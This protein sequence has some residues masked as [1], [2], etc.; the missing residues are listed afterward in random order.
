MHLQN[1][2]HWL[3]RLWRD[4][5]GFLNSSELIVLAAILILGIIPGI[6][7]LRRAIMQEFAQQA[8]S[9][10]GRPVEIQSIEAQPERIHVASDLMQ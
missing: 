1:P 3:L 5:A 9:M 10:S 8:Q 6:A 7:V 4:E 2:V